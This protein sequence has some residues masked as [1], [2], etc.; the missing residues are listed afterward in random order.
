MTKPALINHDEVVDV[1]NTSYII[2]G[3]S[4]HRIGFIHA[5]NDDITN[6][7]N[8][9]TLYLRQTVSATITDQAQGMHIN[10]DPFSIL[11]RVLGFQNDPRGEI[12]LTTGSFTSKA[13][14]A[15][16]LTVVPGL[17]TVLAA[18]FKGPAVMTFVG[19]YDVKLSQFH[20]VGGHHG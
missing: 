16:A 15:S 17:G 3:H 6:Q 8:N 4:V 20:I 9:D 5:S 11:T 1:A 7:S 18:Q 13:A 10:V 12:D 14:I 19:D 2:Q